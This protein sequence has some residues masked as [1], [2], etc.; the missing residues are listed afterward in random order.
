MNRK[1]KELP[2]EIIYCENT[3]KKIYK[4]NENI[5]IQKEKFNR[6]LNVYIELNKS[7]ADFVPKLINYDICDL[8]IELSHEGVNLIEWLETANSNQYELVITQLIEIDRYLF[9]NRI[10]YLGGDPKIS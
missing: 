4:K 6:E 7:G 10:N 2:I 8:W 5:N 1:I 9:D 3:I